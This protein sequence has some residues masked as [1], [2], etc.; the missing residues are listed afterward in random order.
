MTIGTH[1]DA[2]DLI[3][4]VINQAFQPRSQAPVTAPAAR[5]ETRLI[6]MDVSETEQAYL[7]LA[8]LPGVSKD[9]LE[10]VIE[11][12]EVLLHAESKRPETPENTPSRNLMGERFFGKLSRRIQLPQEID[13]Q[14]AQA[15]FAD[16][17]LHLQLP[18]KKAG[19]IRKLEI[20]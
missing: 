4:Q 12:K 9:Q 7:I 15:R 5:Q 16:G 13:D 2:L 3:E 10:V 8:E 1:Y 17:L 18:K 19:G 11:G 20:Q 14:A 6:R